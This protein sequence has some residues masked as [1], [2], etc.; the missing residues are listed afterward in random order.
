MFLLFSSYHFQIAETWHWRP[1]N[2]K[3]QMLFSRKKCEFSLFIG[4]LGKSTSRYRQ[5]KKIR[6]F[7]WKTEISFLL[8]YYNP[9]RQYLRR[10]ITGNVVVIYVNSNRNDQGGKKKE[11]LLILPSTLSASR[12]MVRYMMTTWPF[13]I[14]HGYFLHGFGPLPSPR[15]C[16][17]SP[18]RRPSRWRWRWAWGR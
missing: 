18:W 17:T 4:F 1:E 5:E 16:R 11:Q 12:L 6:M 7:R 9:W 10:R 13:L 8:Y 15:R 3:N 14:L 2:K